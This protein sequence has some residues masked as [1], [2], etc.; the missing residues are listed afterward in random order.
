MQE[1]E[2]ADFIAERGDWDFATLEL[3]VNM[4]DCFSPEEFR[5]RAEYLVEN[6]LEKNPGKPIFLISFFT[7][8]AHY[9]KNAN[10]ISEN[11][12]AYTVIIKNMIAKIKSDHL[13]LIDGREL[14]TDFSELSC[15]LIHPSTAGYV[16]IASNLAPRLLP[17]L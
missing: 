15:D 7:F 13:H 10:V 8:Y 5:K 16:Q 6:T 1:P 3:G 4:L 2:L 17:Y 11:M 14:L 9:Q 12:T